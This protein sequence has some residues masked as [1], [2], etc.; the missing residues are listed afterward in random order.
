VCGTA[1]EVHKQNVRPSF[2]GGLSAERTGLSY[3]EMRLVLSVIWSPDFICQA[4]FF[5]EIHPGAALML[6]PVLI[7]A[8]YS[9]SKTL[10]NRIASWRA[11]DLQGHRHM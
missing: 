8:A 5:R 10:A 9:A 7:A 2:L 4:L 1:G 6:G 11:Q 3:G